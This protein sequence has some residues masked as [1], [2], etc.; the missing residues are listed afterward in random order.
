MKKLAYIEKLLK[1]FK[2]CGNYPSFELFFK[3]QN[4][5]VVSSTSMTKTCFKYFSNIEKARVLVSGQNPECSDF[6][7]FV[8]EYCSQQIW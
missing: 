7:Y 8:F 6:P 5:L 3:S 1:L 4:K 2:S